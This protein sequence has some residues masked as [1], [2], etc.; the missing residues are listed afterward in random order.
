[1]KKIT[2]LLIIVFLVFCQSCKE[3]DQSHLLTLDGGE[4]EMIYQE[5]N[6]KVHSNFAWEGIDLDSDGRALFYKF[7]DRVERGSFETKEKDSIF[8]KDG[9]DYTFRGTYKLVD[10]KLKIEGIADKEGV[11]TYNFYWEL[12]K[13]DDKTE[14]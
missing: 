9:F 13:K 1:M 7:L 11:E 12:I 2:Y 8:L 4:W 14:D 6:N 5:K 10:D 3:S